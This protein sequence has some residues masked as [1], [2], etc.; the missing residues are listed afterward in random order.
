MHLKKSSVFLCYLILIFCHT[1]LLYSTSCFS[2][3]DP[4]LL[5]LVFL[6]FFSQ[7]RLHR[8]KASQKKF[9]LPLLSRCFIFNLHL[10]LQ[11]SM[12]IFLNSHIRTITRFHL[13]LLVFQVMSAI[14][15]CSSISPISISFICLGQGINVDTSILSDRLY[16]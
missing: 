14:L 3:K 9:F 16:Y 5:N 12:I 11:L 10:C 13:T 1:F 4:L 6:L 8:K 15:T 2:C 7:M